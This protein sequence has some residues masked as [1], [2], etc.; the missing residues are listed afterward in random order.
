MAK[1]AGGRSML[2]KIALALA[3]LIVQPSGSFAKSKSWDF[4]EKP[5]KVI[6]TWKNRSEEGYVTS[7]VELTDKFDRYTIVC[8]SKT[9]DGFREDGSLTRWSDSYIEQAD[10]DPHDYIA[11]PRGTPYTKIQWAEACLKSGLLK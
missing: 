10:G 5:V 8:T 11:D 9:V 2:H 6:E 1:Q 4:F 7:G 3:V